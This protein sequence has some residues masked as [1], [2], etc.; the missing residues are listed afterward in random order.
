MCVT[1]IF[2]DS[3]PDRAEVEFHWVK[4]C[5]HGYPEDP[6]DLHVVK[7]KPIRFIQ[8]GEPTSEFIISQIRTTPRSPA[9]AP[10][11]EVIEEVTTPRARQKRRPLS[12]LLMGALFPSTTR[13]RR[14]SSR[15]KSRERVVIINAPPSP[16]RPRTPPPT[17]SPIYYDPRVSMPPMPPRYESNDAAYIVEVSPSRGRQRP[18]IHETS[19]RPRSPIEFRYTSPSRQRS[20]S[21][22]RKD[23]RRRR[24]RQE[25]RDRQEL[26]ELRDQREAKLVAEIKEERERR[27]REEFLML[28]DAEINARPVRFPSPAPRMRSIL[29]PVVDQSWRWTNVIDDLGLSIRGERVIAEA[30]AD[31]ERAESRERLLRERLEAEEAQKERL[32][33]RFTVS[34]GSGPRGRRHRVVY[35]D[36]TYRWAD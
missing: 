19:R 21:Q 30:I 3:Y 7:E 16:T 33:R 32:K 12:N 18:I 11:V 25:E 9:S 5:Q 8:Y 28:Q 22:R 29:R 2:V 23:E 26:R 20:P 15:S 27:R 14:R 1:E 4:L 24:Q 6:C 17:A 10:M 35:D 36:G 13:R 34:E 31:R